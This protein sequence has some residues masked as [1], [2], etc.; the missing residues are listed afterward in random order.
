MPGRPVHWPRAQDGPGPARGGVHLDACFQDDSSSLVARRPLPELGECARRVHTTRRVLPLEGFP[1]LAARRHV[2]G[3]Q[4]LDLKK[5]R[6][7]AARPDGWSRECPPCH[8][9]SLLIAE[10]R[11]GAKEACA[12]AGSL[13]VVHDR[14]FWHAVHSLN[15]PPGSRPT[16]HKLDD[17]A[18][19]LPTSGIC[20]A[21]GP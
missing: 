14:A 13:H 10:V 7:P 17:A 15:S 16:P 1:P 4:E 3:L 21:V 11:G 20:L 19:L 2:P 8:P 5:T 6:A 9:F 18:T 12:R